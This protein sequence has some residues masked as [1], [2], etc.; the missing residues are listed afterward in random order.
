MRQICASSGATDGSLCYKLADRA[1]SNAQCFSA[2]QGSKGC[3]MTTSP[4][5]SAFAG[6]LGMALW[7]GLSG[8]PAHSQMP[9][10]NPPV[11][12]IVN[13]SASATAEVNKDWLTVVF[14]T[15][16][17]GSDAA[18]VQSQLRQ[19]LDAALVE[20]RKAAR[21]G[22]LDVRTGGFALS[23]RYAPKGGIN[24]WQGSTELVVEGRDTQA[25]SALTGRISGLANG[26]TIGRVGF[27]LSREAREKVEAE[28]EA[29][30]ITRFRQR[31]D[32]ISQQFGFTG[33]TV[34]EVNVSSDGGGQVQFNMMKAQTMRGAAM[35]DES[36]PVEAGKA[37][38]TATVQGSVQLK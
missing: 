5:F 1:R 13:L 20:A 9:P 30:A 23:P 38:V 10:M 36:L 37:T 25:I 35:A 14:S 17:D 19:A 34:R 3:V 15:T 29:Q 22:Q 18:A 6:W 2:A 24:G 28:V 11:Q 12:N 31:A 27:S 8:G 32:S 33:Y 26:L 16:R 21:P 7:A 4:R